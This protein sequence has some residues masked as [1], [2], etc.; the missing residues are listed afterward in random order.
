[1]GHQPPPKDAPGQ[2]PA[3]ADRSFP[4]LCRLFGHKD[5]YRELFSV[6]VDGFPSIW[7]EELYCDRCQT[8]YAREIPPPPNPPGVQEDMARLRRG[9]KPD[10]TQDSTKTLKERIHDHPKVQGG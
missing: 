4:L 5:Q 8:S 1:M 6:P 3:L 9:I 7:Y 10:T 2:K